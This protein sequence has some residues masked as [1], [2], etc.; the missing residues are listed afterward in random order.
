MFAEN[1]QSVAGSPVLVKFERSFCRSSVKFLSFLKETQLLRE[2]PFYRRYVLLI[3]LLAAICTFGGIHLKNR[4]TAA[5]SKGYKLYA[6]VNLL[7]LL[8]ECPFSQLRLILYSLERF[9]FFISAN[10]YHTTI[11]WYSLDLSFFL[12]STGS[13][14]SVCILTLCDSLVDEE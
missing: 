10:P 1:N 12:R 13:I 8:L 14:W 4:R 5:V 7:K 6:C 3:I 11:R 2:A 9:P